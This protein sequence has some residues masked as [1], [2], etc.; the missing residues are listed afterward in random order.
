MMKFDDLS[1]KQK[2]VQTPGGPHITNGFNGRGS[3]SNKTGA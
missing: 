3:E 1:F 2:K